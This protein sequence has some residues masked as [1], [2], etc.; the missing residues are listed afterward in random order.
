M[1]RQT[2][3]PIVDRLLNPSGGYASYKLAKGEFIGTLSAGRAKPHLKAQGYQPV[4]LLS[5]LK[6]H[7]ETGEKDVGSL[8]KVDPNRERWQYHIHLFRSAGQV[9]VYSHHEYRPDLR[10]VGDETHEERVERLREHYNPTLG[11]TYIRGA[12]ELEL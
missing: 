1:I 3:Y 10:R 2:L 5:A 7:P 11:E 4:R 12:T 9:E 8:R 6:Y